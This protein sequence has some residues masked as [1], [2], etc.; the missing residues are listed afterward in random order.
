MS[1]CSLRTYAKDITNHFNTYFQTSEEM[2]EPSSWY[3]PDKILIQDEQHLPIEMRLYLNWNPIQERNHGSWHWFAPHHIFRLPT[4]NSYL[5][6]QCMNTKRWLL[7]NVE[8]QEWKLSNKQ[9][10]Y[11][12][13]YPNIVDVI[14]NV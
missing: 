2:P 9:N 13:S 1:V 12:G 4:E 7:W 14:E 8:Q 3:T 6:A 11:F 10:L 5:V